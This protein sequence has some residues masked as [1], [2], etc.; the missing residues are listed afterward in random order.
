MFF[1]R[2]Y[3]RRYSQMLA[4]RLLPCSE[5]KKPVV[6][7]R[8]SFI[9]SINNDPILFFTVQIGLTDYSTTRIPFLGFA[10]SFSL[11][12]GPPQYSR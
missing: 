12:A 1:W 10:K 3:K 7:T 5:L 8:A 2:V 6:Y 11:A 4:K 9:L